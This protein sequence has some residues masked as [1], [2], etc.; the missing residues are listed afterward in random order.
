VRA[1]AVVVVFTLFGGI[2]VGGGHGA[3]PLVFVFAVSAV[4]EWLPGQVLAYLGLICC[5]TALFRAEPRA[6]FGVLACGA[7]LFL[8]SAVVIAIASDT[9]VGTLLFALPLMIATAIVG[10]LFWQRRRD[11]HDPSA[12]GS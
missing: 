5:V 3:A 2:M 4:T 10:W 11:T 1:L 12:E 8:G 7:G 9:P 6:F